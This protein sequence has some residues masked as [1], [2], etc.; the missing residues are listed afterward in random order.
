MGAEYRYKSKYTWAML[1]MHAL[2]SRQCC[3]RALPSL[4]LFSNLTLIKAG[5]KRR[6]QGRDLCKVCA[7]RC[8]I[9]GS[10]NQKPQEIMNPVWEPI[11][12][13]PSYVATSR[14]SFGTRGKGERREAFFLCGGGKSTNK[15]GSQRTKGELKVP[16]PPTTTQVSRCCKSLL[17]SCPPPL[18][19]PLRPR[20]FARS[21]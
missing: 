8:H 16:R 20:P 18:R 2:I 1:S 21:S 17:S 15:R 6:W 7:R 12:L 4:L 5:S 9:R 10:T 11:L 14:T 13:R 3:C 19:A